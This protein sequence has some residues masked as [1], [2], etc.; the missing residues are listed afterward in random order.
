[1]LGLIAAFRPQLTDQPSNRRKATLQL[2]NLEGRLVLST[3]AVHGILPN[4]PA[5]VS[6][7]SVTLNNITLILDNQT[8][9]KV[10][11]TINDRIVLVAGKP[12]VAEFDLAPSSNPR[13]FI[14]QDTSYSTRLTMVRPDTGRKFNE[15]IGP[16]R[17]LVATHHSWTEYVKITRTAN[18]GIHFNA[19]LSF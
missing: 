6:P 13:T 3:A 19:S 4:V 12:A 8:G 7:Q 5:H 10:H 16:S 11:V 9:V 15:S 1:M 17:N 18:G 14:Y 2:E